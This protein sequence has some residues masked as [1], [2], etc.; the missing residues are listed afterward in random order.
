MIR[1]TLRRVG[2]CALFALLAIVRLRSN[3]KRKSRDFRSHVRARFN[4]K[5]ATTKKMFFFVFPPKAHIRTQNKIFSNMVRCL[6]MENVAAN[7]DEVDGLVVD[8]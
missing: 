8:L 5:L 4:P 1:A 3:L 6:Q 2:G 7:G